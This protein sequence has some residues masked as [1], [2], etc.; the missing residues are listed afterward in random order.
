[1]INHQILLAE[2]PEGALAE[3]HFRGATSQVA[4]PGPGEVLVRAVLLSIDPASRAWMAGRT[5]RSQ[6]EAGT[7]M[8]GFAVAEVLA[9][10][11][12]AGTVVACEPGWQEYALLP[13]KAVRP[14]QVRSELSHYLGVL[15]ITGLTAYF[16]LLD[17][18]KPQPGDTVVISAAAGATG[19]VA[20]QLA[21]HHGCRVVGITGSAAKN[22]L[23]E[24]ELGFDAALNHH[25]PALY[26]DLRGVC[27]AGVDVYFDN[28]GGRVLETVLPQMNVHGTIVCCGVVSQYDAAA[29]APGPR[30]VPGLLVTKR[31]RMQGFLVTD[32]RDRWAEAE[33]QLAGLIASGKVKVVEEIIDGLAN[34]PRA[35][36]GLLAG[37]NI[38]KRIVRVGKDPTPPH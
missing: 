1:M 15:G 3:R 19:S 22:R 28:V 10:D 12:P 8:P 5:Y 34:A 37:E 4:D 14:I 29:P 31:L 23:L 26:E 17:V 7:V 35:L 30:S 20:G 36:I 38:G 13:V 33:N 21:R 11:L 6:L 25:S 9:G 2:L 32:Y 24:A 18:G 16:G 27:P